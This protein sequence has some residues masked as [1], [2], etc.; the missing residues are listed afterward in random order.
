MLYQDTIALATD[1]SGDVTATGA[2]IRGWIE[3]IRYEP[4]D[5]ATG[6][7]L[8]ITGES[9][10]TPILTITNAGTSKVWWYP[11]ALPNAV[12]DGAAGTVPAHLIPLFEESIQVVVAQ[13]GASRT[14][15]LVVTYRDDVDG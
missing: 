8:T 1:G 2:E 13:G 14:G 15:S 10:E 6:A 3:S 7:D 4:G 12:A 9:S 5:I 11:R